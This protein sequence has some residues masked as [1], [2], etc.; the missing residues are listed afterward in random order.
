MLK[1][2]CMTSTGMISSQYHVRGSPTAS[3]TVKITM[4]ETASC[5]SSIST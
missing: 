5:C 3:T 2:V 1:S 4:S